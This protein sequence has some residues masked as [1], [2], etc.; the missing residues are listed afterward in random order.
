MPVWCGSEAADHNS[1]PEPYVGLLVRAVVK[2]TH[3]VTHAT[4]TLAGNRALGMTALLGQH[5]VSVTSDV[6]RK[7]TQ[8]NAC[9]LRS[10]VRRHHVLW[11]T[12]VTGVVARW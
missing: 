9:V 12:R 3:T 4:A 6:Q 1:S 8:H 10:V 2:C 11:L 7:A 5:H